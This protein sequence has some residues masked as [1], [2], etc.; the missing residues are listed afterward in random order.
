M[1]TSQSGLKPDYAV[2]GRRDGSEG[3]SQRSPSIGFIYNWLKK[4]FTDMIGSANVA[5][6]STVVLNMDREAVYTMVLV[7]I[8]VS[9]YD[10]RIKK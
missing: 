6:R 9:F 8:L 1:K 7:R 4:I 2:E 3:N 10:W 5:A